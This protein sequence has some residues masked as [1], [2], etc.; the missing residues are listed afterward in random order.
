MGVQEVLIGLAIIV[1]LGA[2][3]FGASRASR[4]RRRDQAPADAATRRNFNSEN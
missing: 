2:L 1:F 4:H 3:A